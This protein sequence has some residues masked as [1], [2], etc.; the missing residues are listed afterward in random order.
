MKTIGNYYQDLYSEKEIDQLKFDSFTN[1][2]TIPKLSEEN[3]M[4][5]EGKI[6]LPEMEKVIKTFKLNKTPGNDGL[7]VEFYVK[8]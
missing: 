2:D 4:S 7:P 6:T 8:F 5:C 1:N 3:K